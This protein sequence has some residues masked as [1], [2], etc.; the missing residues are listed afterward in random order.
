MA[1]GTFFADWE[2]SAVLYAGLGVSGNVYA[3]IHDAAAAGSLQTL[4]AIGWNNTE[5]W[6]NNTRYGFPASW[7]LNR[8]LLNI[9]CASL[10]A[11]AII[12]DVK[13]Y[14]YINHW[15]EEMANQSDL[16]VVEGVF[17]DPPVLA[18]YGAQLPKTVS[19]G[20]LAFS[21]DTSPGVGRPEPMTLN[22]IG[23]TWIV[24][25]GDTLLCLRLQGDKDNLEPDDSTINRMGCRINFIY[26]GDGKHVR[27]NDPVATLITSTSA[28]VSADL[29]G[30]KLPYLE[31]AYT[32]AP[33][34]TYPRHR[35]AYNA[36]G[37]EPY[38]LHKTAWQT[39]IVTKESM[40]ADLVGLGS[41]KY[42]YYKIETELS[43]GK[44]YDS[45]VK[46]FTTLEAFP[47][48]KAYALAGE[49]L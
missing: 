19:G 46:T 14:N 42:H 29:H 18:D 13:L 17:S 49:E 40:S 26:S 10:P 22:T 37:E 25:E 31:V 3:D 2:K 23:K 11:A 41:G 27:W 24:K 33:V 5:Y 32:G 1:L 39:G 9:N 7:R 35:F 30:Y 38:Y 43:E 47:I 20:V 45:A 44:I 28:H 6:A 12:S 16:H 34:P 8:T 4:Y 15:L 21:T 36:V 48:S